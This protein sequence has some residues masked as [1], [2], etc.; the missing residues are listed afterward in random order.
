[1]SKT[2]PIGKGATLFLDRDGVLNKRP[3]KSYVTSP[4]DFIWIN[5]SLESLAKLRKYFDHIFVVTN[6]QGIGKGLMN[7]KMLM[8]IHEHM[9]SGIREAGG[10][11]DRVYSATGP[12]HLDSFRRKPAEGMA[13]LAKKD[14]PKIQ[15]DKSWMVGDT[16]RD[17]LFG[18]RLGMHTALIAGPGDV[19]HNY[20]VADYR[21]ASLE[22]F[23]NFILSRCPSLYYD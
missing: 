19:P 23:T 5:G 17:M 11:V 15:F 16:L 18:K 10:Q 22:D 2:I 1:M 6:Q 21:F 9:L 20:P 7:E 4:G 3:G 12:R 14:F 13:L 8:A